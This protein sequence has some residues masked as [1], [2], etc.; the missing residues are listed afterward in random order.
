MN[1]PTRDTGSRAN[2]EEISLLEGMATMRSIRRYSDEPIPEEDLNTILWHA[3]R[4]PSG[5]NRQPFR[6]LVLRDGP[7]ARAARRLLGEAFR[8]GW[9]TKCAE[10]GWE[11]DREATGGSARD[12]MLRAMQIFVDEFEKA[13]VVVLALFVRYR[14]LQHME[15]ASIFPA[16]QNLLL[17][18][19]ALGYGGCFSG[20]H[21]EVEERLREILAIPE[22]VEISLT[23]TLGRPQGG[24]GPLRRRPIGDLVFED[25]WE[26]PA[27][28]A[29]D[30]E[31]TRFTSGGPPRQA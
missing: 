19:R 11:I 26:E 25:G 22:G 6:F 18:A 27:P 5:T 3:T 9:A 20:W 12:R 31:G 4:A 24:H 30:P 14:P 29:R 10:E 8:A 2:G 7:R 17:A 13:P 28:W 15:G 16:C 1:T 21:L 23:I